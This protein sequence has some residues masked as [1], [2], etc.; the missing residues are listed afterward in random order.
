MRKPARPCASGNSATGTT[1]LSITRL[2][3]RICRRRDFPAKNHF[4][5]TKAGR[6]RLLRRRRGFSDHGRYGA[7]LQTKA[8]LTQLFIPRQRRRDQESLPRARG[9]DGAIIQTKAQTARLFRPRCRRRGF[10]DQGGVDTTF[11]TKAETARPK[12]TSISEQSN[13]FLF[14]ITVCLFCF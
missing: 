13:S 10:P 2:S 8:E 9:R 14:F 11:H 12:I 1:K 6:A 7:T 3:R 4:L 5:A